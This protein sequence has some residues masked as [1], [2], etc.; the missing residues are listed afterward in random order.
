MDNKL[1]ILAVQ[2][3]RPYVLNGDEEPG[4]VG[5]QRGGYG[6]PFDVTTLTGRPMTEDMA[7]AMVKGLSDVGYG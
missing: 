2:D 1:L 4:F 6:N 3:F 7:E 5:L